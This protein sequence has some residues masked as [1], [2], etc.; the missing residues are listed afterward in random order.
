MRHNDEQ[1]KEKLQSF[2]F[3]Q[4]ITKI[5]SAVRLNAHKTGDDYTFKHSSAQ[6]VGLRTT[7][8]A[9]ETSIC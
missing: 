3:Y 6:I 1:D 5:N 9:C 2:F 8:I 4:H 7:G